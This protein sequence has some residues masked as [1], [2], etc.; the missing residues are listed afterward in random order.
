MSDQQPIPFARFAR[1]LGVSLRQLEDWCAQGRILGAKKHPW[2][3]KWCIYPPAK[4][5][6]CRSAGKQGGGA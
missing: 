1:R 4:L 2:T 5:M 3:R 6:L